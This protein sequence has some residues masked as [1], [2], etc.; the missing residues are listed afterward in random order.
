VT[1]VPS[2]APDSGGL[3]LAGEMAL[4]QMESQTPPPSWQQRIAAVAPLSATHSL[5]SVLHLKRSCIACCGDSGGSGGEGGGGDGGG[6][7]GGGG[8]A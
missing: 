6:I 4:E 1:A 7:G 2:N 5:S 3:K 8:S